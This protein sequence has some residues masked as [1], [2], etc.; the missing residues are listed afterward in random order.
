MFRKIVLEAF[1][2]DLMA[3]TGRSSQ[4]CA[5]KGSPNVIMHLEPRPS[6]LHR[7]PDATV[8]APV[9]T[10]RCRRPCGS[11]RWKGSLNAAGC[12]SVGKVL[13]DLAE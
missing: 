12:S 6:L 9:A 2:P 7:V 11:C 5:S 8:G 10:F 3:R 4:A 13:E 1:V